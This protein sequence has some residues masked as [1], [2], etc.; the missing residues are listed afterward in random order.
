MLQPVVR[1]FKRTATSIHPARDMGPGRLWLVLVHVS[2][3]IFV[4]IEGV[5]ARH[6]DFGLQVPFFMFA[7]PVR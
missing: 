7:V 4:R 5:A 1:S 2:P 6:A 3:Q